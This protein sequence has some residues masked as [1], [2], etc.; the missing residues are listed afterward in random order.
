[1]KRGTA[2]ERLTLILLDGSRPDFGE[3]IWAAYL[4]LTAIRSP[5]TVKTIISV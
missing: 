2:D 1:M 5:I 3:S 4:F